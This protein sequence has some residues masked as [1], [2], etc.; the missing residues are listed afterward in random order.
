MSSIAWEPDVLEL[1]QE[2]R[3]LD[4]NFNLG[5]TVNQSLRKFGLEVL[6]ENAEAQKRIADKTIAFAARKAKALRKS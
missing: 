2:A 4:P 1:I 3:N 5:D 6:K